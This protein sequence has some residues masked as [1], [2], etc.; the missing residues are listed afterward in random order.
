MKIDYKNYGNYKN[1]L[2][3]SNNKSRRIKA[4]A[5]FFGL[6]NRY[7]KY[8]KVAKTDLIVEL[9]CGDGSLMFEMQEA[10]YKYLIGIEPS[11]TYR[12]VS[13]KL[14][15][16]HILANEYFVSAEKDSVGLIISMDCFEH[17]PYKDLDQLFCL[18]MNA[19]KPN[20]KI[21]FRVPNM[22]SPLAMPNYYGDATH[23][24]ALNQQSVFQ[25]V[26]KN[27]FSSIDF[28]REPFSYPR[29][30]LDLLALFFWFF[31]STFTNF[32]LRAFGI[33]AQILTPNIVCVITK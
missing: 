18:A 5:R 24:T 7:F 25:L 1:T 4:I 15:I 12:F 10:G 17:I 2:N 33:K 32:S 11:E 26:H 19:L 20:G 16:L 21:V 3:S 27:N 9:G 29:S 28:Y 13:E 30:P 22:A 23:V 14:T 31:Y 6:K 8:F